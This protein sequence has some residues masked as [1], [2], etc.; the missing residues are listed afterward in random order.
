MTTLYSRPREQSL[1][2][3]SSQRHWERFLQDDETDGTFTA[4]EYIERFIPLCG[5]GESL[6]LN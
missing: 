2:T 3:G 5:G 4:F 1:S 6:G